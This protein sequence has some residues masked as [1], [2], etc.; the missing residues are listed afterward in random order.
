MALNSQLATIN[1]NFANMYMN[2]V[3]NYR[4]FRSNSNENRHE[5]MC[6]YVT[7]QSNCKFNVSLATPTPHFSKPL[8]CINIYKANNPLFKFKHRKTKC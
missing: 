1:V 2:T 5:N 8:K 7:K 6:K 3:S 4:K